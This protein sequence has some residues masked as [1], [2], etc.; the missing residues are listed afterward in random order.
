MKEVS[1]I[2]VTTEL[3]IKLAVPVIVLSLAGRWV[4]NITGGG[5]MFLEYGG[6]IDRCGRLPSPS[7][8]SVSL[9]SV[10]DL[11]C[12]WVAAF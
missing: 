1:L 12:S 5:I 8:W 3:A 7:A 2:G 6:G 9:G 11:S 4:D 10:A